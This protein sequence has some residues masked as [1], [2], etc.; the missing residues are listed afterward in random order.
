MTENRFSGDSGSREEIKNQILCAPSHPQHFCNKVRRLWV[1]KFDPRAHQLRE[2]RF[3]LSVL[4]NIRPK[5][6][7][8]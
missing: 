8:M 7:A 4:V 5:G 2:A 6:E 3:C 1:V